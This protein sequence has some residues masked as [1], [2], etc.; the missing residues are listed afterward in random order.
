MQRQLWP[1]LVGVAEG[2]EGGGG[3]C[4]VDAPDGPDFPRT[5]VAAALGNTRLVRM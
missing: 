1:D 2:H 3:G 5:H 4:E